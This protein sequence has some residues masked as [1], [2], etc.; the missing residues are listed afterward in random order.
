LSVDAYPLHWPLG[1][2]RTKHPKRSRFDT[3]F[4]RARNEMIHELE[5]LGATK[6][7]ISSNLSLRLDGLP[8]SGQPQPQDTG[9]AV[10]FTLDGKEQCIPCD[11]WDRVED[12]LQAIRLTIGA[13][14]GLD[15]WGA[16]SILD[17]AFRGFVALPGDQEHWTSV[18]GLDPETAAT[19][20][21]IESAF[22]TMVK[23]THPDKG[24]QSTEFQR[25]MAARQAALQEV[26]R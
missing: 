18:L 13:L 25:L 9:I 20:E 23:E 3:S 8:R 2:V 15:R 19:P 1:W 22:R 24:G 21:M 10:Y 17:A 5:L 12:N 6:L 16:K 11:R 4:T 26:K 14:R 7:V